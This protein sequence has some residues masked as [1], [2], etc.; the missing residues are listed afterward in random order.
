VAGVLRI[1]L[2]RPKILRL[3][4][5]P[6]LSL[7]KANSCIEDHLLRHLLRGAVCSFENFFTGFMSKFEHY[8]PM[9]SPEEPKWPTYLR[10]SSPVLQFNH[11]TFAFTKLILA[12]LGMLRALYSPQLPAP[13]TSLHTDLT[14]AQRTPVSANFCSAHCAL[15]PLPFEME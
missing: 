3:S 13:H 2:G 4:Y 7:I 6:S 14:C 8:R 10:N 12:D 9:H 15:T 5:R 11:K 1:T